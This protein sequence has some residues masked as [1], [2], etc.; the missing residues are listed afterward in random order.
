MIQRLNKLVLIVEDDDYYREHLRAGLSKAGFEV[1]P[2]SDAD[3]KT[4]V[5]TKTHC[6]AVVDWHLGGTDSGID[7]LR[8][9]RREAPDLPVFLI[10]AFVEISAIELALRL[11]ASDF[12]KKP[13]SISELVRRLEEEFSKRGNAPTPEAELPVIEGHELWG[14]SEFMLQ[15]RKQIARAAQSASPILITGQSGTGK[16]AVARILHVMRCG[17]DSPFESLNCSAVPAAL[18]E[19]E[20]FGHSKGAYTDAKSISIGL[21]GRANGGTVFLDEIGELTPEIQPKFLRVLENREYRPLGGNETLHYTGKIILATNRD[22]PGQVEIGLFRA[23]LYERISE[24]AIHMPSLRERGEDEIEFLAREFLRRK[25]PAQ[26]LEFADMTLAILKN[27]DYENGNVRRLRN[28]IFH[29]VDNRTSDLIVP[30][31]L[32]LYR[33]VKRKQTNEATGSVIDESIM[34]IAFKDAKEQV[35][36]QFERTYLEFHFRAAGYHI[37]R[38]AKATGLSEKHVSDKLNQY[39][40]KR[41]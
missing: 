33:M 12:L 14:R 20:L 9:L 15:I 32:P 36:E 21:F 25:D 27:Y 23:D 35:I 18:F 31:D 11:G 30:A 40:I 37:G 28:L 4:C 10:S 16:E 7:V 3:W 5:H 39:G 29:A 24:T 13:L 34:T 2:R 6:A 38:T 1:D 19:S 41:P 17:R 8:R 26:K 22:L